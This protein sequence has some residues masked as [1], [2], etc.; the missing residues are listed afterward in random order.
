MDVRNARLIAA[1]VCGLVV[2]FAADAVLSVMTS[3]E[4]ALGATLLL[5]MV[6]TLSFVWAS[7]LAA[8]FGGDADVPFGGP[9]ST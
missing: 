2:G 6:T 7:P 5:V 1:L 4:I 8:C 3:E 9:I